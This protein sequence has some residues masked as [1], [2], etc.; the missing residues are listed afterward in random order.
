MVSNPHLKAMERLFGRGPT[1]VFRG[2]QLTMVGCSVQARKLY[3]P[4]GQGPF[5][6]T[7]FRWEM[8][9][10]KCPEP[11]VINGVTSG[12]YKW[13]YKWV[14]GVITPLITGRGPPCNDVEITTYLGDTVINLVLKCMVIL[15][16][17]LLYILQYLGW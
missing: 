12:P 5:E 2:R 4:L 7:R 8:K 15:M 6:E 11:F 9:A 1:N 16:D 14:F 10:P 3:S 17:F 13:P